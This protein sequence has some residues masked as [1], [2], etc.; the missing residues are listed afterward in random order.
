LSGAKI[1]LATP[2]P[3]DAK[4]LVLA[5]FSLKKNRSRLQHGRADGR[6]RT[7]LKAFQ[8]E[9][10]KQ[11]RVIQQILAHALDLPHLE[12]EFGDL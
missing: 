3:E 7:E 9:V 1:D 11:K 12:L 6:T 5:I 4:R 8:A 10:D 2:W